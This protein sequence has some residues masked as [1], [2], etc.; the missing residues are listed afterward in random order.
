VAPD[1]NKVNVFWLVKGTESD[2]VVEK[3]LKR[4]AGQLRH[5]LSELRVMGV[6]PHI[7]FV[8]GIIIS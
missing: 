7:E 6:V 1:F 4:S 5:E 8:K 3:I 2:E